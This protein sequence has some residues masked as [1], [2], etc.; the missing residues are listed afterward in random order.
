MLYFLFVW[1]PIFKTVADATQ[2]V[3]VH[4]STDS[5]VALS[6]VVHWLRPTIPSGTFLVWHGAHPVEV[7]VA[8]ACSGADSLIGSAILLP[9][10]FTMLRGAKWAIWTTA[11][12]ALIG[13][14][15]S[16]WVRLA[17]IVG[18]V[19]WIG[20]AFTFQFIHPVMG[21]VLF[22]GLMLALVWLAGKLG[23][24]LRSHAA[25]VAWSM[26]GKARLVLASASSLALF[27]ILWPLFRLP[28]GNFGNPLPVTTDNIEALMPS[29]PHLRRQQVYYANESSVLGLGSAT[30]AMTYVTGQGAQALVEVWSSPDAS[31]LATYGFRNCLVYHGDH[32]SAQ[33]SFALAPGIVATAY[34]V[35][36]PP[37]V[38]G[39][40][41]SHYVDIEWADAIRGPQGVRYLRWSVA[42]FPTP[43]TLW[44]NTL[45]RQFA[46]S[47]PTL[48]LQ[49]LT[50]PP[51]R[52]SWPV[53]LAS[54]RHTLRTLAQELYQDTAQQL[55]P[56][57]RP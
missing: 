55:S 24:S 6:Q 42:A 37:L 30:L 19:H 39:G 23:L 16:N 22:F 40:P 10:I 18:S 51:T 14:I 48:G 31:A 57:S 25:R 47:R 11:A 32:L 21:F 1:P 34:L 45:A 2:G 44:A 3:L 50:A 9:L 43:S 53:Q 5:L 13:A 29:L 28:P 15:I 33:K 56:S 41:S 49:G 27:V 20:P 36:L 35:T 17:L 7:I 26:P 12:L 8:Q 4:W 52:G 38:Y 54:M 46:R